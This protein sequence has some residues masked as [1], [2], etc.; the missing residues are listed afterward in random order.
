MAEGIF[1]SL[2]HKPPY[3]GRVARIDSCGT[4]GYHVGEEPDDRTMST[5]RD[6]GITDYEHR[7]RKVQLSDFD[8]F[9]YI[10]AMDLSN[11]ADLRRLQRSKPNGKAKVQLF[12][13]YSGTG[14]DEV[15][16]D[17]YYGGQAGFEMAF[18]QCERFSAN[19]LRERFPR[20]G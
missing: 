6:H 8:I 11:L 2:A 14:K 1:R 5:L 16:R 10:F 12:G 13:T 4:A 3:Q 20:L 19:F 7:C 15:V 18:S 9:D 17:P